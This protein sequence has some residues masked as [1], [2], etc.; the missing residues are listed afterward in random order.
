MLR[1]FLAATLVL[2]LTCI[3]SNAAEPTKKSKD[4]ESGPQ[5]AHIK[6][7]GDLDESPTL[8]DPIFGGVGGESLKTKLD[9]IA[10]AQKDENVK[11]LYLEF[12]GLSIGFAKVDE[13]RRSEERR[14]GKDCRTRRGT[15]Q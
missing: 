15:S 7:S 8:P 5:I 6:L 13:L 4:K 3:S 9:R 2:I 1:R 10:K 11:A 14:V 12:G